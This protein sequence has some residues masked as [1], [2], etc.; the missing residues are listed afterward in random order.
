MESDAKGYLME[1]EVFVTKK[2]V[3]LDEAAVFERAAN[4][5]QGCQLPLDIVKR[6]MTTNIREL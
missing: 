2:V 1:P 3:H 6:V 4:C 5:M